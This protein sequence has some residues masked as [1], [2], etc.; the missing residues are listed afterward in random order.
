MAYFNVLTGFKGA[1]DDF[2]KA[3]YGV[4]GFLL[5][6]S[7]PFRHGPNNIGFCEGHDANNFCGLRQEWFADARAGKKPPGYFYIVNSPSAINNFFYAMQI[8]LRPLTELD[9]VRLAHALKAVIFLFELS[10]F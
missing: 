7:R 4:A 3:I 10:V 8:K 1:F 2:D 6:E 9:T 5:G